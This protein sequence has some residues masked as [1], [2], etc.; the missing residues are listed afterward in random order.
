MFHELK[1]KHGTKYDTPR[2]RLWARMVASNLHENLD[3]PPALP[4]F[5][6]TPSRSR[7][8][9]ISTV[10]TEAATAVAKAFGETKKQEKEDTSTSCSGS[11]GISPGKAVDLR[12]KNYQQ[13]RYIQQ[14]FDDGIL[15]QAEYV[16]Q[17]QDILTSLKRL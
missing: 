11:I 17:K 14:L 15:T 2:L 13:L 1:E 5:T 6:S 9:S 3:T 12:M 8:P 7:S 4:A 10:I 16:E